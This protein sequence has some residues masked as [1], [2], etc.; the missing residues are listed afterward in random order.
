MR[1]LK[2][3][4]LVMTAVLL[5]VGFST[6]SLA[7]AKE[8]EWKMHIVW[9]PARDE[10]KTYQRWVDSIN[11]RTAGKLKITLY[12][13]GALGVKDVD[14]LRIL[15]PGNVIQAAGLYPGYVSRDVPEFA[16]TLPTGVVKEADHMLPLVPTLKTIFS[17]SYDKWGVKFV[18]MIVPQNRT[19][20]VFCKEPINTLAKL[21]GKKLR[22]FEKSLVEAFGDLGVAAQ[23]IPQYEMYTALQT[24]VVDCAIYATGYAT[25]ISL[26]EVTPYASY[27]TPYAS[28]PLGILISGK[29]WSELSPDVQKIITDET[30]KL[31]KEEIE[32]FK[33]ATWDNA[34][35]MKLNA[36]GGTLLAP[37]PKADRDAFT[38]AARA[39]WKRLT[40]GAGPGGL[41]NYQEVL[42]VLEGLGS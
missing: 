23:I 34:E 19:Y 6:P 18:G 42:K 22:V 15:P 38:A 37:F 39:S 29:S 4:A 9:I 14:M 7:Q 13:G 26:Q 27:I 17:N 12:P 2:A 30:Q 40:E 24:G 33:Q 36:S 25:T 11:A 5:A 32:R 16:F 41:K 3:V 28:P 8:I 1:R 31:E 21:K 20:H 10:T 35:L